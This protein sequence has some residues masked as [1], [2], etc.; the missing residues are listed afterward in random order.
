MAQ[1]R[2]KAREHML[3]IRAMAD[4]KKKRKKGLKRGATV[5]KERFLKALKG[6][7]GLLRKIAKRLKCSRYTLQNKLAYDPDWADM[8]AAR[9]AEQET[10]ADLA[11]GTVSEMM[12]QR[13]EYPVALRA[14][15]WY[16]EK[17]PIGRNRGYQDKKTVIHEGGE[18]PIQFSHNLVAVDLLPLEL[19]V[20]LLEL[21][22]QNESP[23]PPPPQ[24]EKL[25]RK[26]TVT[27]S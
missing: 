4:P 24:P 16:L 12:K 13:E 22:D 20:K 10:I 15:T 18:N 14:S 25:R 11:E 21:L 19:R 5:T 26:I 6:S 8:V 7:G 23:E 17:G 3:R 27:R 1:S 9:M 2:K